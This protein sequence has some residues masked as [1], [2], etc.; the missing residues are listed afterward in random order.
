MES[1]KT[2]WNQ[3][4]G[5]L[6]EALAK[7]FLEKQGFKILE[8]RYRSPF[9]EIDLVALR[10]EVLLFAEVKA[11][12]GTDFGD[13]LEAVTPRKLGHL[14][15]A[16]CGF[17]IDHPE[18]QNNY[19]WEMAAIAVRNCDAESEIELVRILP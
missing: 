8:Q 15:R 3:D 7:K 10:G 2:N 17:L 14:R 4:Q 12:S 5:L 13:P 6:G 11:R 19:F 18:Y 1:G 16:V 9:G